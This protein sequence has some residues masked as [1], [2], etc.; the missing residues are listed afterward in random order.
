[1]FSTSFFSSSLFSGDCIA[2]VSQM[3]V[4]KWLHIHNMVSI[5]SHQFGE[6]RT[7]EALSVLVSNHALPFHFSSISPIDLHLA[8]H[9]WLF[10][11]KLKQMKCRYRQ[12]HSNFDYSRYRLGPMPMQTH[13][14]MCTNNWDSPE[15]KY[16]G[17]KWRKSHSTDCVATS[18]CTLRNCLI[19]FNSCSHV[20]DK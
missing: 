1:M 4:R 3:A 11:W 13:S 15:A 12:W 17:L 19:Q 10:Y 6:H 7:R 16:I 14:N 8:D 20:G 18:N 9:R 5:G 2:T